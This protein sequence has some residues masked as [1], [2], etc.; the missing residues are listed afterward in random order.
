VLV[1]HHL[2]EPK[3]KL[4]EDTYNY[5]SYKPNNYLTNKPYTPY[6]EDVTFTKFT[7]RQMPHINEFSPKRSTAIIFE[8]LCSDPP[9]I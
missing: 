1:G 3:W 2:N 8:D 7:P 6:Y 4:V 9:P 5:I